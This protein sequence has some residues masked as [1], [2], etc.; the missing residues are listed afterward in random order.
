MNADRNFR[1]Y[2]IQHTERVARPAAACFLSLSRLL[3]NGTINRTEKSG[4][5]NEQSMYSST[6]RGVRFSS[7]ERG[8]RRNPAASLHDRFFPEGPCSGERFTGPCEPKEQMPD[9]CACNATR[10]PVNSRANLPCGPFTRI[11]LYIGKLE[12][13]RVILG[14]RAS[15][16]V[17]FMCVCV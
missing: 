8:I 10:F 11:Q 16:L 6:Y 15:G 12:K 17:P 7:F 1:R 4:E 9:R 3:C 2:T 5:N 13:C 14:K